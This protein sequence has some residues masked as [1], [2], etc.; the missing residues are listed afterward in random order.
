MTTTLHLIRHG[1]S[2]PNVT[3]I[4][5]GMRG[6]AGLTELGHQ[7]AR[8]LEERLRAEELSADR[9]YTSTLPRALQTA[10]YVSRALGLPAIHE[11]DLHELRPG[12]ADGLTVEQWRATYDGRFERGLDEHDAFVPFS[13]GGESWALFLA[14]AGGM[15][16]TLVRR[17]PDETVVA[18]CHGGVLEASFYLALGLGPSAQAAGFVPRNT[19][20][21]TWRYDPPPVRRNWTLVSFND[22]AHLS[23]RQVPA[24]P[25]REAVPTPPDS[26]SADTR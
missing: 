5:G 8:L 13:P 10:E 23:T 25:P 11:D 6:D 1:E 4:I 14:R 22:A 7:Q 16:R 19:S 15:L 20:I 9:L 2:V 18:V 3:P 21:T 26:G 24:E 12:A 17:H